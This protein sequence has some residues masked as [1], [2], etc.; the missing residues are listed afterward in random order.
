[1]PIVAVPIQ[2][3][4]LLDYAVAHE[5]I[6]SGYG[7]TASVDDKVYLGL[8]DLDQY[9][10]DQQR[11]RDQYEINDTDWYEVVF[12]EVRGSST[13]KLALHD[14]WI[15]QK[16][17]LVNEV[18]NMNLPEQGISGQFRVTSIKHILPQKKPVDDETDDF[19]LQPITGIFVHESDNVWA[20]RFD[21]GDTL[22]V[23]YNHPIYSV[24]AG[25]WRL[26]GE[27][28]IGDE[29]L[30]REDVAILAG[31]KH[32][33]GSQ[34]VWNLEVREWHNFLVGESGIVVHNS[35]NRH[36][37]RQYGGAFGSFESPFEHIKSG[38]TSANRHLSNNRNKNYF[39]SDFDS[40]LKLNELL[41]DIFDDNRG[42]P[43]WQFRP[44]SGNNV[45]EISID[46]LSDPKYSRY[47]SGGAIG[48]DKNGGALTKF[49]VFVREDSATGIT[50][51]NMFPIN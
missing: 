35:C 3:V 39:N 19:G 15:N 24:T 26:A 17:Y 25:D 11:E 43:D 40:D 29:V 45:L 28:A 12:E 16:G 49:K 22:G 2:E 4:Q 18:V 20:L 10:S 38:H 31:K 47:L 37:K 46:A 42:S 7:L 23:T 1:M 9:T 21:N 6:N 50:L 13:A 27:L 51:V 48:Y 30:T 41:D 34:Q 14:D 44:R 36:T 33:L 5:T 32:L 8:A